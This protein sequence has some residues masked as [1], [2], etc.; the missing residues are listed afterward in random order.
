MDSLKSR[1]K[2]GVKNIHKNIEDQIGNGI[3]RKK[4]LKSDI[5]YLY[6]QVNKKKFF[7]N[8]KKIIINIFLAF[9]AYYL[10]FCLMLIINFLCIH[11]YYYN[12]LNFQNILSINGY[13]ISIITMFFCMALQPYNH[14]D[15]L[16]Y[17]TFKFNIYYT[18]KPRYFIL[19][20]DFKIWMNNQ[21]G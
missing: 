16:K 11:H 5:K 20:G 13:L 1:S 2:E 7:L 21:N 17:I 9:I 4:K 15:F 10:N 6:T 14:L 18:V 3:K 12:G 19:V 8:L